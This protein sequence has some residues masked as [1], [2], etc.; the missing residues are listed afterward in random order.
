[1]VE[2]EQSQLDDVDAKIQDAPS[3]QGL[4]TESRQTLDVPPERHGDEVG[5]AHGL[6]FE[7]FSQAIV[8][9]EEASPQSL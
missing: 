5:F 2:N 7:F 4:L 8:D 3:S 9:R 6:V 1:M